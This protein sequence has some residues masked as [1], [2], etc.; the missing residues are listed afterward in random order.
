M[1]SFRYVM[2]LDY[3]AAETALLRVLALLGRGRGDVLERMQAGDDAEESDPA[4]VLDALVGVPGEAGGGR[5]QNAGDGGGHVALGRFDRVQVADRAAERDEE[6]PA[7]ADSR[8]GVA[9]GG[10]GGERN[11]GAEDGGRGTGERFHS[12]A[13]SRCDGV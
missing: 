6:D 2:Y 7:G 9:P 5:D 10:D 12:D 4:D 3:E 8:C 13:L 11:D 1:L